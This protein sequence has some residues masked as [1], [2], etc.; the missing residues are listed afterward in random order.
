MDARE[1][2]ENFKKSKRSSS[3]NLDEYEISSSDYANFLLG[4]LTL[5]ERLQN[6]DVVEDVLARVGYPFIEYWG[7]SQFD[8]A[9]RELAELYLQYGNV[10]GDTLTINSYGGSGVDFNAEFKN[11][12]L[13]HNI[14]V[15][16]LFYS[17]GC[18]VDGS[19]DLNDSPLH[20]A[21]RLGDHEL[22]ELLINDFGCNPFLKNAEGRTPYDIAMD[23][24]LCQ[25]AALGD[26]E[27]VNTLIDEGYPSQGAIN[28]YRGE[29][30]Y[31]GS[32]EHGV[33]ERPL[34]R[35]R[36]LEDVEPAWK[37]ALDN[38]HV[39]VFAALIDRVGPSDYFLTDSH[40]HKSALWCAIDTQYN[41]VAIELLEQG[42]N[43]HSLSQEFHL[44]ASL[45]DTTLSEKMLNLGADVHRRLNVLIDDP[46]NQ[47]FMTPVAE[48]LTPL[49]CAGSAEQVRLLIQHGADVNSDAMGAQMMRRE[50]EEL[51]HFHPKG[52]TTLHTANS[53][54][55]ALELLNAGAD[56]NRALI[57]IHQGATP[58]IHH[59]ADGRGDIADAI[60]SFVQKQTLL[61]QL[62]NTAEL[63]DEQPR[64]RRRM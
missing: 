38:G 7:G 6:L 44:A 16:R 29:G 25:T 39:D 30:Y 14:P 23:R 8:T 11:A 64:M 45:A 2:Y 59:R 28:E 50:N 33:P 10:G 31:Y 20:T 19:G 61:A 1:R 37:I 43:M 63:T 53:P 41:S 32:V 27:T 46:K 18:S 21:A 48:G 36:I 24:E 56:S 62:T 13:S 26:L 49:H 3:V 60:D 34:Y 35:E 42:A 55:I 5:D 40:E 17:R 58:A 9:S 47:Y 54:E 57:D 15:M 4:G 22:S 51:M 52:I 12:A